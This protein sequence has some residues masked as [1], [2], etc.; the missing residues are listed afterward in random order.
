MSLQSEIVPYYE[1]GDLLVAPSLGGFSNNGVLYTSEYLTILMQMNQL[2]SA[3]LNTQFAK[4]IACQPSAPGLLQR[5]PDNAGGQEG[6][7]DYYGYAAA[8]KAYRLTT[9][10]SKYSDQVLSYGFAHYGSFN[11]MNPGVWTKD[12][13]LWRQPQLIAAFL[14]AGGK[15]PAWSWPFYL[16]AAIAI[17]VS[18]RN[19]PTGNTDARFLSWLLIYAVSDQ[20]WLCRW[21]AKGW[22]ERLEKDYGPNGMNACCKIYFQ[23][24]H[25]FIQYWVT[26]IPGIS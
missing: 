14:G 22:F 23:A 19:V 3:E 10:D 6:P 11:N 13:F 9:G 26:A 15:A 5:H 12:S 7:D 4:L 2:D 1:T 17:F 8:C 16:W 24:G 18:C 20:S 21:A 25:P